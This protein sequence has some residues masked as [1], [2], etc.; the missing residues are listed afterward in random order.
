MTGAGDRLSVRV[1]FFAHYRERAGRSAR[2]LDLPPGSTVEDLLR[3]LAREGTEL[4]GRASVAVN[5]AYAPR[6]HALSDGDEVALIPPV[7]GG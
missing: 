7:S 3:A 2:D 6:D 1:R 4:P 5:H